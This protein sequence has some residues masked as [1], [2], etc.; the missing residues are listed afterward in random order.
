M[1]IELDYEILLYTMKCAVFSCKTEKEIF[2]YSTKLTSLFAGNVQQVSR[3]RLY[4][5][6]ALRQC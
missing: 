5:Y 3:E 4:H 6:C 2:G 1:M